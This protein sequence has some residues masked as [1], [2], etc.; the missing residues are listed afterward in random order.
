MIEKKACN[1]NTNACQLYVCGIKQKNNSVK[2][3]AKPR[4]LSKI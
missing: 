1:V 4:P 3:M 2:N